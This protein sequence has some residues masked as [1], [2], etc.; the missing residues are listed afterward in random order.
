MNSTA[1][2]PVRPVVS[3]Q[4]PIRLVSEANVREHWAVKAKRTRAQRSA[5]ALKVGS[6]IRSELAYPLR[7]LIT[8]RGLRTLDTDNLARAC[9]AVRDGVADALGVDD[10][11][12]CVTWEYAQEPSREYS[13]GIDVFA[14]GAP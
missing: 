11:A 4:L 14:A 12:L 9:K 13:V 10:G 5:V 8:R 3:A 6:A 7:V 1:V 2:Q